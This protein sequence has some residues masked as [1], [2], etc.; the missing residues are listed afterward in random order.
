MSNLVW[1]DFVS[2]MLVSSTPEPLG[3]M[4]FSCTSGCIDRDNINVWYGTLEYEYVLLANEKHCLI[5][6]KQTMIVFKSS[7]HYIRGN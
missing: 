7:V 4:K 1:C 3:T 6:L 2:M 5:A